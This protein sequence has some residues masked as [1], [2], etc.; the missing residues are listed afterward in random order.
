MLLESP[1]RLRSRQTSEN[2]FKDI[3]T[4]LPKPDGGEYGKY[5]NLTALND[6]RI[7]KLPYSIKILI[8]SAIH[9]CDNFQVTEND[10]EKIIDWEITSPKQVEIPFKP[11]RVLLQ[12]IKTAKSKKPLPGPRTRSRANAPIEIEKE[13]TRAAT[14]TEKQP[15]K[16]GTSRE[17]TSSY[18]P[19]VLI[20]LRAW[21]WHLHLKN[22]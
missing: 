20:I 11:A 21:C 7:D 10:V 15:K 12:R 16:A 2:P 19:P 9:N 1:A 8:E 14:T 5:Y 17:V 18:R 6:P 4:A 22:L 3:C 13:L